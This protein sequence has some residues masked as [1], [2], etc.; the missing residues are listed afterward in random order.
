MTASSSASTSGAPPS[1]S[2]R[3]IPASARAFVMPPVAGSSAACASRVS[4]KPGASIR[5][6]CISTIAG[7]DVGSVSATR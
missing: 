5:P 6:E 7:T 4:A 3:Y 2:G 1:A